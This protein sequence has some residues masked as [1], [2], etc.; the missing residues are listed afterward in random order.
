MALTR[1]VWSAGKLLV[2][3]AAL[4][5]T[6]AFSFVLA[7]RFAARARDVVVP[8]LAGRTVNEASALLSD[9]GLTLR[10]EKAPRFDA[11]VPAGRVLAQD[12]PAGSSTRQQRVVKV[13]V[14]EGPASTRVP[15]LVGESERAAQIRSQM[16]G[17]SVS[18]VAA[19]NSSDYPAGTVVAQWPP[20]DR[21]A[22]AV[23]VLVNRGE[24]GTT[25]VMPDLIGVEGARAAEIMRARG[26]RV[27]VVGEQPYPGV[28][29]GTVIR[30]RPQG[31]FRVAPGD[32]ISL[33]VTR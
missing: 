7:M 15:A 21:R 29:P 3:V 10:I 8:A 22:G 4:L 9:E 30:Q 14:S 31:G 33:E 25:Y 16:A 27:S 13:W 19:V 24:A 11:K 28:P 20:A 6:Y 32:P 23:A 1:R 26:L 12:P 5:A 18:A 2:L 17:L